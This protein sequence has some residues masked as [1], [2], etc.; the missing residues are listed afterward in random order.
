[1]V[2]IDG[3]VAERVNISR[4]GQV[5]RIIHPL[6]VKPGEALFGGLRALKDADNAFIAMLEEYQAS[7]SPIQ[8]RES[9]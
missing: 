6:P 2:K 9:L 4:N 1:V 7:N 3:T 8:D 5:N